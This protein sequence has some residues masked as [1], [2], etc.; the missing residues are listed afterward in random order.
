[1]K[2]VSLRMVGVVF[3]CLVMLFITIGTAAAWEPTK[4]VEFVVPAGAGGGGG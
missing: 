1:M 3:C 4:P 2:K